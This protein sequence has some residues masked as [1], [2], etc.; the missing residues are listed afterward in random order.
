MEDQ[1][2]HIYPRI[3]GRCA[4]DLLAPQAH[5]CRT[6]SHT[7]VRLNRSRIQPVQGGLAPHLPAA[8]HGNRTEPKGDVP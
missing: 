5:R 7:T 3:P 6:L 4:S 2:A 8:L 1:C